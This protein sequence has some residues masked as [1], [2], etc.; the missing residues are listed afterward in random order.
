[1]RI[2]IMISIFIIGNSLAFAQS[3]PAP[4]DTTP[5]VVDSCK[6]WFSIGHDYLLK[7]RWDDAIRNFRRS[8]CFNDK[9]KPAYLELGKAFIGKAGEYLQKG[10][11]DSA[12][13]FFDSAEV[14]YRKVAE[15]DSTDS[16]GWQGLG[17]MYGV[18]KKD[19]EKGVEFYKKAIEVDPNNADALYGL[20]KLYENMGFKEKADSVYKD[21]I[22]K[23]PNSV[24]LRVSYGLFLSENKR[25]S[26]C[27]PHLEKALEL[28]IDDPKK[29]KD[30]R[31]A[32]VKA[33]L[34]EGKKNPKLYSKAI[35]QIDEL[36]KEDSLNYVNYLNRAEAYG[37]LGKSRQALADYNKAIELAPK[38]AVV[39]I[40]KAVYL[41]YELKRYN[42]AISTI[43]KVLQFENLDD[44]YKSLAY[45]LRGDAYYGLGGTTYNKAKQ[46]NDREGA[47]QAYRYYQKAIQDYKNALNFAT[48][49]LKNQINS[50]IE[51][52]SKASKKAF[53]V[54]KGIEP[55]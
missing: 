31:T 39:Y 47:S 32:L 49:S 54:W 10:I 41:L 52:A 25:Y 8:L 29:E 9:F 20:A 11:S 24:G 13:M 7:K 33:Y 38:N 4:E 35:E 44:Y 37:G 3:Q 23:K 5:Q 6:V 45:F 42:D 46:N 22:S 18:V 14:A 27:I 51:R 15:I 30:V 2:L 50:R 26:E 53:G 21:A 1:M 19:Y 48:G 34:E 36:I 12:E 16:R 28:G 55:W 17:F 40:K 43:N